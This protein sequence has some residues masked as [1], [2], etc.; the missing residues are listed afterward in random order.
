MNWMKHSPLANGMINAIGT[1]L[2]DDAAPVVTIGDATIVEGGVL[3]FPV[4]L[5]NPII[6][7]LP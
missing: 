1:I 5:S 4:S 2:D 3:S 6:E 7:T